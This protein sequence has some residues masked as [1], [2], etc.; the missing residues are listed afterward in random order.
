MTLEHFL[1]AQ[2][3]QNLKAENAEILV[4][5]VKSGLWIFKMAKLICFSGYQL[6]NLPT[7]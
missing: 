7:Y 3:G 5:S 2:I 4:T 1:K 6:E